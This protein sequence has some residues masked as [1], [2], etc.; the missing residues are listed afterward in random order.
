[1]YEYQES[2]WKRYRATPDKSRKSIAGLGRALWFM[3]SLY[4][5]RYQQRRPAYIFYGTMTGT[6]KM[7]SSP[8]AKCLD[9]LYNVTTLALNE[10]SM[11]FMKNMTKGNKLLQLKR[12]L[13]AF[14]CS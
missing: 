1:M 2:L 10:Q 11:E 9:Q 8:L 12:I 3:S 13:R 6:A 5:K 7:F 4:V 14:H